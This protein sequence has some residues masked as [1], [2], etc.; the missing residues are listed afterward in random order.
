MVV[1]VVTVIIV[2]T[3]MIVVTVVSI[4]IISVVVVIITI[5]ISR[6]LVEI[7]IIEIILVISINMGRNVPRCS[8]VIFKV[9]I[10][11]SVVVSD[12]LLVEATLNIASDI[13]DVISVALT[14]LMF[15]VFRIVIIVVIWIL[16]WIVVI[17]HVVPR[18]SS[19]KIR[20]L[21]GYVLKSFNVEITR[22]QV[23][24]KTVRIKPL[25]HVFEWWLDVARSGSNIL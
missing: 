14:H 23:L 16:D 17:F 12:V 4:T 20:V 6:I 8:S 3:W 19:I 25:W 2:P 22:C 7:T 18:F 1:T 5:E 9:N 10:L 24:V 13:I 21:W 15:G 11:I